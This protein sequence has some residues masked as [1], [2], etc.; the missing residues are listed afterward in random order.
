MKKNWVIILAVLIFVW[1][2]ICIGIVLVKSCIEEARSRID[3]TKEL[4]K[5]VDAQ[6]D[7]V[8]RYMASPD[9][10]PAKSSGTIV[11]QDSN[12]KIS[13]VGRQEGSLIVWRDPNGR[14]VQTEKK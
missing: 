8:K 13:Y 6:K 11:F 14:I 9:R 10:K 2:L 5:E 12:G 1:V 4:Q 7:A 3:T